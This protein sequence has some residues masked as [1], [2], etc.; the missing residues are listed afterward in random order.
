MGKLYTHNFDISDEMDQFPEKHKL[1]KN[2]QEEIYN[3]NRS[4]YIFI[5]ETELVINK[6]S[7]HK[8]LCPYVF[9]SELHQTLKKKII[10]ILYNLSQK[11]EAEGIHPNS[12]WG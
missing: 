11:V 6:L 7:K 9:T 1:P 2:I 8:T 3:Q 10:W 12:F 5:K 4:W